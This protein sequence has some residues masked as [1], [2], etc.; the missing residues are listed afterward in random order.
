M[1][2]DTATNR[3][4]TNA[5]VEALRKEWIAAKPGARKEKLFDEFLA[6]AV[7]HQKGKPANLPILAQL[8]SEA[9]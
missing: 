4:P 6:A 2:H 1:S 9:T 7:A 8:M 3:P 5:E